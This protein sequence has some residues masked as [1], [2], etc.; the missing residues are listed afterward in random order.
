MKDKHQHSNRRKWAAAA[1]VAVIVTAHI[2]RDYL[3]DLGQAQER[4]SSGSKVVETPCGPIEY[5]VAGP[6]DG[7]PVLV[8][9]G[10]GGGFDQGLMIGSHLAE[11]GFRT[12]APSRFGYLGTPLPAPPKVSLSA[13]VDAHI[14]LLD[15]LNINTAAVFG[16]SAGAPSSMKF[17]QNHPDRCSS[18]VL[19]V[20]GL[21]DASF[22]LP[23]G[24]LPLIVL[25]VLRYDF[26]YWAAIKFARP[27]M[28]RTVFGTP[29]G[30]Y[31]KASDS[32]KARADELLY[33]L[34]PVSAR[35]DG[36]NNECFEPINDMEQIKVPTLTISHKDDLYGTYVIAQAIANRIPGAR[37]VGYPSGGHI[38]I[39][40][41]DLSDSEIAEFLMTHK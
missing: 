30:L 3:R 28:I 13:Q 9:H 34:L 32:E 5:A 37:F 29:P 38:S 8:V 31:Y 16:V 18:L 4:I 12:I 14:C 40:Y 26:L 6:D 1:I 21:D 19:A 17:A 2:Y 23:F 10:S 15:A 22:Q 27:V 20:P 39:G 33:Q 7:P 41:S 36:M 11:H 25:G 24:L 35:S